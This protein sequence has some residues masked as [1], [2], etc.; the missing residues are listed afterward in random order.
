MLMWHKKVVIEHAFYRSMR[1]MRWIHFPQSLESGALAEGTSRPTSRKRAKF[2]RLQGVLFL[3]HISK[4]DQMYTEPTQMSSS[5]QAYHN[6][7]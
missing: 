7:E 3:C 4:N 1:S 6:H 5:L 2:S